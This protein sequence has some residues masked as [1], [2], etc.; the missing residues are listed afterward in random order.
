MEN[1]YIV[2]NVEAYVTVQNWCDKLNF[3]PF[4]CSLSILFME[5]KSR[6]LSGETEGNACAWL[7]RKG[8]LR[9]YIEKV[10]ACF[11]ACW[12]KIGRIFGINS[13]S[14]AALFDVGVI[15]ENMAANRKYGMTSSWKKNFGTKTR[16]VGFYPFMLRRSATEETVGK[17][18]LDFAPSLRV[19]CPVS[20]VT[21]T[22][23]KTA[24]PALI[25]FRE[26]KKIKDTLWAAKIEF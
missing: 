10:P 16:G 22:R 21:A 9:T 4:L 24:K 15:C 5:K 11:I 8:E 25:T 6:K 14:M 17:S 20:A 23:S 18:N 12:A 26:I 7:A 3:S 19:L 1:V 2:R 13:P